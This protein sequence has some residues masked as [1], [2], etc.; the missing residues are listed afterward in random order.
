MA[1]CIVHSYCPKAVGNGHCPVYS[2]AGVA[3]RNRR[4]GE[5]AFADLPEKKFNKKS[6]KVKN[7]LKAS[8]AAARKG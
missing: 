4:G 8:K 3:W 6:F 1:F 2:S 7:A 5:C